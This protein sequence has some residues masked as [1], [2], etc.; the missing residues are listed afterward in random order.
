[1]TFLCQN[2][3]FSNR[4]FCSFILRLLKTFWFGRFSLPFLFKVAIS[5]VRFSNLWFS[6]SFASK[7]CHWNG[8]KVCWFQTE[9]FW[10][11]K[12]LLLQSCKI[13]CTYIP[14]FFCLEILLLERKK[15]VLIPNWK[16]WHK[17]VSE[18]KVAKSAITSGYSDLEV[19]WKRKASISNWRFKKVAISKVDKIM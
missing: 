14:T 3:L 8:R 1:M 9:I 17:K 6:D 15:R 5:V 11:K 19:E 12:I 7:Y 10:R 4:K 18:S 16:F 13:L 2:W